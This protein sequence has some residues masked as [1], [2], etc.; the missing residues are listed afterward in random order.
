MLMLLLLEINISF[1]FTL[2]YANVYSLTIRNEC[3]ALDTVAVI[4]LI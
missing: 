1:C 2:L 3:V 4:G